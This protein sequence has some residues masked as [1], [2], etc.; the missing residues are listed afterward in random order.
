MKIIAC[1]IKSPKPTS[2][3]KLQIEH[4]ESDKISPCNEDSNLRP[5]KLFHK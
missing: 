1:R 5:K 2:Y 4:M 3:S